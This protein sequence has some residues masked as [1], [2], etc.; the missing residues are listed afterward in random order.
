MKSTQYVWEATFFQAEQEKRVQ[1]VS[2]SDLRKA[3]IKA[4]NFQEEK[5]FD[6]ELVALV[7]REDIVL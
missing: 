6:G 7:R 5:K 2:A 3:R 1:L 4:M